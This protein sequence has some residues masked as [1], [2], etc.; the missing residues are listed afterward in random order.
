MARINRP[1][2]LTVGGN[3]RPTE[4]FLSLIERAAILLVT[5]STGAADDELAQE[6]YERA[7]ECMIQ[8]AHSPFFGGTDT[9]LS[10]AGLDVVRELVFELIYDELIKRGYPMPER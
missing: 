5:S 7:N 8:A 1:H 3:K 6:L 2:L 10:Y 9:S 4:D